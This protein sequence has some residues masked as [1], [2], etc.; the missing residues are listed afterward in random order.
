MSISWTLEILNLET[1]VKIL[2]S[3]NLESW[4]L[5]G[6]IV[7]R[8]LKSWT[9]ESWTNAQALEILKSWILKHLSRSW[10]LEILEL[11]MCSRSWNLEILKSW[12]LKSWI[13]KSWNAL[14]PF[15]SLAQQP[16][17]PSPGLGPALGSGHLA[18]LGPGRKKQIREGLTKIRGG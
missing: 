11:E 8:I 3:W 16:R 12:I 6:C 17:R 7:I 10:N 18:S 9:L 14:C 5:K 15:G 2:T 13:L 1:F 4:N